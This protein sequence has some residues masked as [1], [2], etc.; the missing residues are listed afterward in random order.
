MSSKVVVLQNWIKCKYLIK[1]IV[2]GLY[3]RKFYV[4]LISGF[5]VIRPGILIRLFVIL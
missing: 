2:D 5:I 3:V 1:L 4:Y